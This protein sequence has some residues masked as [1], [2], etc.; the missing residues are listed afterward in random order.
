MIPLIWTL[1]YTETDKTNEHFIW[2]EDDVNIHDFWI[3]SALNKYQKEVVQR[4][5]AFNQECN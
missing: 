3:Q 2:R 1:I 5:F 4:S